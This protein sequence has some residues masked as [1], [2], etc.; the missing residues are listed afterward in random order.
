MYEADRF[1][2]DESYRFTTSAEETAPLVVQ[3][4]GHDASTLLEAAVLAKRLGC[5]A[6]DINLGC[7]QARARD[8]NYG[9]WLASRKENW[10]VCEGLVRTLAEAPELGGLPIFC[11]IRLQHSVAATVAFALRLEA[12]GAALLAVHGRGLTSA[13]RPRAG[14]ADLAAVAA[15][16]RALAV[17]V[18][19]NGNVR[20]HA[21]IHAARALTGAAGVMVGEG[22]LRNPAICAC[23]GGRPGACA[24]GPAGEE[25]VPAE[26]AARE[27]IEQYLALAQRHAPRDA[28]CAGQHVAWML[29]REGGAGAAAAARYAHR[30]GIPHATITRLLRHG[31]HENVQQLADLVE[32]I[33]RG[34]ANVD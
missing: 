24:A 20:R 17:P 2:L 28:A 1:L 18:L 32:G 7:P 9:A 3:L 16:A 34:E 12:A 5:A 19:S 22:L 10:E 11:K 33:F 6:I 21:D 25:D 26:P 30:F 27:L 4:A 8:R 31:A 29:G 15:V 14:P 23:S 13:R